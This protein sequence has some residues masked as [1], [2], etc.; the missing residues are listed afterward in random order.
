MSA[1]LCSTGAS[2]YTVLL[3]GLQ[4]SQTANRMAVSANTNRRPRSPTRTQA[5]DRAGR[6]PPV[7]E[8]RTGRDDG[9]DDRRRGRHL[10][11]TFFRY[12]DTKEAAAFPDHA[13]RV[14][15]LERRLDARLPSRAPLS[16]VAELSRRSAMEFF[17]NPEL[18][19]RRY[20]LL[21]SDQVLRDLERVFD[22]RYEE[23]LVVFLIACEIERVTACAFAAA[24]VAVVNAALDVWAQSPRSNPT[25]AQT[26]LKSGLQMVIDAFSNV[27]I[28][29][30]EDADGSPAPLTVFVASDDS[31]PGGTARSRPA[32]RDGQRI[33]LGRREDVPEHRRAPGP[34]GRRA[35]PPA[36]RRRARHRGQDALVGLGGATAL[37]RRVVVDRAVGLGRVPQRAGSSASCEAGRDSRG[38]RSE[39]AGWP[40]ARRH[41]AGFAGHLAVL[42]GVR[43]ALSVSSSSVGSARRA[44]RSSSTRAQLV[45]L[46][47]ILDPQLGHEVAPARW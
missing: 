4:L 37:G 24:V 47:E 26:V 34:G 8:A 15:D 7:R 45:D 10:P 25:P 31:T 27:V 22:R 44:A 5:E 16:D 30:G 39:T 40:R 29:P 33:S 18:Y 2:T 43:I 17:D 6:R 1:S 32:W 28:A 21:R 3:L 13:D 11:R 20:R 41:V 35:R 38:A 36:D 42:R 46:L 9:R 12:F 19:H 14:A 23:Q